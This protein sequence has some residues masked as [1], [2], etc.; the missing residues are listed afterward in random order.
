[1]DSDILQAVIDER[2]KV[3]L[4]DHKTELLSSMERIVEK[5]SGNSNIQQINK[6]SSIVNG[7]QIFKRKSNEEQFKFNCKVSTTLD[8][9]EHLIQSRQIHESRQK[10]AEGNILLLSIV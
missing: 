5:I 6:I 3:S 2:L 7:N 9:A 8:E 4:E 1:M 10:I